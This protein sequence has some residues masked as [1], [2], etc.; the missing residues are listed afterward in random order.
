MVSVPPHFTLFILIVVVSLLDSERWL[1][2]ANFGKRGIMTPGSSPACGGGLLHND[3]TNQR[4]SQGQRNGLRQI[5]GS[6]SVGALTGSVNTKFE[7]T[8]I[9]EQQECEKSRLRSPHR[10]QQ[11]RT[12]IKTW[13]SQLTRTLDYEYGRRMMVP[14][15]CDPRSISNPQPRRSAWRL[16]M[17]KVAWVLFLASMMEAF[18]FTSF[19]QRKTSPWNAVICLRMALWWPWH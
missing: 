1:Q 3:K 9:S 14:E 4:K 11:L 6:G 8:G 12:S 17:S 5:R 15:P 2:T 7:A 19:E 18:P 13:S 16:L 10:P